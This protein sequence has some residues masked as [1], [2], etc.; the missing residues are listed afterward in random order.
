MTKTESQ[1]RFQFYFLYFSLVSNTDFVASK[2]LIMIGS[3]CLALKY[4]EFTKENL[5]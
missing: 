2:I 4:L 3:G 5:F 1:I